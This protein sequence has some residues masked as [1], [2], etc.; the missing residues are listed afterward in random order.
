MEAIES[1]RGIEVLTEIYAMRLA[2]RED[3]AAIK[4]IVN[5]T[6]FPAE[7]LDAMIA[8]YLGAPDNSDIWFVCERN[9]IL[10]GVGFCEAERMT[11]G[12]WNLLA[13]GVEP[14]LQSQGAGAAMMR[15]LEAALTQRGERVLIVETSGLPEY[16]RTRAFYHRL[17][18]TEEAR[19][20]DFYQNGEDKIVF[21]KDLQA[22]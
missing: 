1:T 18:Y 13:I 10:L 21:W 15:W 9:G 22:R 12:T 6:L 4:P 2:R 19:I 5:A 8:P 14:A 16:A 17:G 3:V 20:R 11:S 7:M